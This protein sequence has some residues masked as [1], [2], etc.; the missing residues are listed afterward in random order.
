MTWATVTLPSETL[1]LFAMYTRLAAL[2]AAP[3]GR[4]PRRVGIDLPGLARSRFGRDA[5]VPVVIEGSRRI[6]LGG[7]AECWSCLGKP[8]RAGVSTT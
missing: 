7:P 8:T 4:C 3:D 5:R 2:A 6:G 1:T